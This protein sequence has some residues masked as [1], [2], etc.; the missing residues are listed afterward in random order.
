[1][2]FTSLDFAI[3]L[4]QIET[5]FNIEIDIQT[6]LSLTTVNDLIDHVESIIK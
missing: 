5:K 2:Q 4:T 6:F 3:L 1:M